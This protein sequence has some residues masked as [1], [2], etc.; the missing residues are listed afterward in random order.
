METKHKEA[1]YAA[2]WRYV[3]P[4]GYPVF[5]VMV[6][7]GSL[8]SKCVLENLREIVWAANHPDA[9]KQWEPLNAEINWEDHNLICDHCGDFIEATW[10]N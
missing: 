1:I 10:K 4:S 9:D 2:L 5:L 7:G 3:W 6:D 8:C